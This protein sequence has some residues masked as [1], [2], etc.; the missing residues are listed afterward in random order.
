MEGKDA[1][2]IYKPRSGKINLNT[3]Q[4]YYNA[5]MRAF[6]MRTCK[7]YLHFFG[8]TKV[9]GVENP[10]AFFEYEGLDVS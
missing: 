9:E 7:D 6:V 8:Y 10:F 2:V 4:H 1:G 3:N 5:E